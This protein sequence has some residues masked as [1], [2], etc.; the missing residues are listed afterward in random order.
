MQT[1]V[2]EEIPGLVFLGSEALALTMVGEWM[3]APWLIEGPH[4]WIGIGIGLAVTAGVIG[5]V[6][7]HM[8]RSARASAPPA[9]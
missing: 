7:R 9:A 3:L 6:V 4:L 2:I 5:L 8:V 1:R